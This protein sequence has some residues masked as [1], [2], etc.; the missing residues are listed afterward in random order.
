MPI[1][2]NLTYKQCF[3]EQQWKAQQEIGLKLVF[4]IMDESTLSYSLDWS[5]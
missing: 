1:S 5:P 2:L 3:N 4:I